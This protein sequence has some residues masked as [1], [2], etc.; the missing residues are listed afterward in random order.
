MLNEEEV[1]ILEELNRVYF[2]A[3]MICD[4]I[5]YANRQKNLL[6]VI[7]KILL[8]PLD[9]HKAINKFTKGNI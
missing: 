4:P 6:L 2:Q 8:I 7:A 3:T 1:N 9:K 5:E